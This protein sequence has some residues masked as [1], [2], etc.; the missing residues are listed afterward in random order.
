MWNR[1]V[2]SYP[3]LPVLLSLFFLFVVLISFLPFLFLQ[4]SPMFWVSWR[5]ERVNGKSVAVRVS[6]N[7]KCIRARA[8]IS[9]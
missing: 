4:I 7:G 5:V 9:K 1:K 3:S 6:V 8:R 2:N